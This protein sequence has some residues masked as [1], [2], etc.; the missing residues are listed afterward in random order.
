MTWPSVG[1]DMLVE[2]LVFLKIETSIAKNFGQFE[3]SKF[4][5]EI[6]NF[7]KSIFLIFYFSVI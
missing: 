1:R 2:I 7:E 4:L 5:F 3:I 6:F